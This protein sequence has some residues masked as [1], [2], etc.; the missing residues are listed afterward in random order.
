M[1][2]IFQY[3]VEVEVRRGTA[4][5]APGRGGEEVSLRSG[6][7]HMRAWRTRLQ[8][9]SGPGAHHAGQ[10]RIIACSPCAHAPDANWPAVAAPHTRLGR[11]PQ[12]PALGVCGAGGR[13]P[14]GAELA[15]LL[16]SAPL[17]RS[18]FRAVCA[19][20]RC[21]PQGLDPEHDVEQEHP[22][23]TNPQQS[24]GRRPLMGCQPAG[25]HIAAELGRLRLP[26]V[27]SP[28]S[29]EQS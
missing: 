13:A 3:S 17:S 14:E 20:A 8:R 25:P 11:K 1:Y 16:T 15:S 18:H 28:Q 26:G 29:S 23:A 24:R 19:G 12:L 21:G 6:S 22:R 5:A 2:L 27:N 9:H 10:Q 4:Q 7:A